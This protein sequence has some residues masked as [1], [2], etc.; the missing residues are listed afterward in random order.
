M[1]CA[2]FLFLLISRGFFKYI[3][4]ES[5]FIFL[6]FPCYFFCYVVISCIF[7]ISIPFI[8]VNFSLNPV[9]LNLLP[10]AVLP[11]SVQLHAI[12]LLFMS[13][14]H[15]EFPSPASFLVSPTTTLSWKLSL[16]SSNLSM[17]YSIN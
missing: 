1:N 5:C 15:L 7:S 14:S 12:N 8:I 3:L 16:Q 13:H 6:V 10:T 17:S 2:L 4:T 11:V 9:D